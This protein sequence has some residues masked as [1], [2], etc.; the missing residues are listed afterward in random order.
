MTMVDAF[1]QPKSLWNGFFMLQMTIVHDLVREPLEQHRQPWLEL[2]LGFENLEV[3]AKPTLWPALM[4]SMNQLTHEGFFHVADDNCPWFDESAT[5]TASTTVVGASTWFKDKEF[6]SK[7]HSTAFVG[8]CLP[9]TK[10]TSEGF[11]HV[12]DES[13]PWFDEGATGAAS[14]TIVGASLWFRNQEVGAKVTQR[15]A[16]TPSMNQ[17]TLEWFFHVADDNCPWFFE[18]PSEQHLNDHCWS[19]TLVLKT[20]RLEPKN[21]SMAFVG[22]CLPPTKWLL[23]GFFMSEMRIVHDLM[24]EPPEQHLRPLLELGFGSKI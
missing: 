5:G 8:W 11:F 15:P 18:E 1:H 9:P 2:Q 20:D 3:G 16:L 17:V 22:W 21:H 10:M 23:M 7:N 4:P 24:K 12:G 6:G 19:F 14:L 13:C